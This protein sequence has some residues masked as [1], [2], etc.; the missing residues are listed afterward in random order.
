MRLNRILNE[1]EK[2]ERF[3]HSKTNEHDVKK[4]PCRY[5]ISAANTNS[6][7]RSIDAFKIYQASKLPRSSQPIDSTYYNS[8]TFSEPSS[9]SFVMDSHE[10]RNINP[11]PSQV[12]RRGEININCDNKINMTATKVSEGNIDQSKKNQGCYAENWS[13]KRQDEEVIPYI[14]TSENSCI[15]H[16]KTV[17]KSTDWLDRSSKEKVTLTTR[18]N[19]FTESSAALAEDDDDIILK[20]LHKKFS[21]KKGRKRI[22]ESSKEV[23]TQ[24]NQ[25]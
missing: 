8:Y 22:L 21:S 14:S 4:E 11:T 18:A 25:R 3:K 13:E 12:Y 6:M 24:E 23:Q 15:I 20:Y 10:G 1:E 2:K 7:P 16:Q 5:Q 9:S 19:D 17:I